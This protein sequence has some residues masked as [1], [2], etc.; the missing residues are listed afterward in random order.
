[1]VKEEE[2]LPPPHHHTHSSEEQEEV[3][4]V[5]EEEGRQTKQKRKIQLAK[6]PPSNPNPNHASA[7]P[8]KPIKTVSQ[9]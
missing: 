7:P 3:R 5:E 4:L 1:L 8:L 9:D 6:Y 2:L